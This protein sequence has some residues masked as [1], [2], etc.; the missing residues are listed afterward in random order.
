[1]SD[2]GVSLCDGK[3][4]VFIDYKVEDKEDE[5]NA[6]NLVVDKYYDEIINLSKT[7]KIGDTIRVVDNEFT[8]KTY[9]SW[10]INNKIDISYALKWNK[11]FMPQ[12]G[13]EYTVVAI[14]PYGDERPK[15]IVVLIEDEEGCYLINGNGEGLE[16]IDKNETN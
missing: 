4:K 10:F 9:S 7:L 8:Y 14:A 3:R 15:E 16:V 11:L 13:N 12:S 5:R 2:V 6:I 1:M